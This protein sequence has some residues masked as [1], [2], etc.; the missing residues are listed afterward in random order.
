MAKSRLRPNRKKYYNNVKKNWL[1]DK[2]SN[3]LLIVF[4]IFLAIA[5]I[6]ALIGA[7]QKYI[8]LYSK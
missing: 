8:Q 2:K 4:G 1:F 3:M 6:L 7:I 5:A